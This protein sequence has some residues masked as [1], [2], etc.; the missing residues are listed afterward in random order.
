MVNLVQA[1][2]MWSRDDACKVYVLWKIMKMDGEVETHKIDGAYGMMAPS[3]LIAV[4]V[5]P[6]NKGAKD[7][8][9]SMSRQHRKQAAIWPKK[10]LDTGSLHDIGPH[11]ACSVKRQGGGFKPGGPT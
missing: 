3:L 9:N 8:M 11:F 7:K 4:G 6:I 1:G 5:R 2:F 10:F